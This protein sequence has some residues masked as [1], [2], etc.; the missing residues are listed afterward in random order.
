MQPILCD[1]IKMSHAIFNLFIITH[2]KIGTPGWKET[3]ES[4]D[5]AV[6]K[7][8]VADFQGYYLVNDLPDI[9]VYRLNNIP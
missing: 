2:V 9:V 6:L 5:Y 7:P 4:Y 8:P 3:D 1:L